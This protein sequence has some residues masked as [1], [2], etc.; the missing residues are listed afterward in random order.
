MKIDFSELRK[1]I[2]E[3]VV[4]QLKEFLHDHTNDTADLKETMSVVEAAA[5]FKV[6]PVTIHK[7][8]KEGRLIKHKMGRRTF[9]K[10]EEVLLASRE[11]KRR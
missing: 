5:Y 10:R 8:A 1:A 11:I 9:F 4:L 6:T 2:A 7:Y 3:D